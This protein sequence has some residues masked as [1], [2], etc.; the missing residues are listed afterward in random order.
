M[1]EERDKPIT[2]TY[3]DKPTDSTKTMERFIDGLDLRGLH[4]L[5][6]TK[7]KEKMDVIHNAIR[8]IAEKISES[9]I[10]FVQSEQLQKSI[11]DLKEKFRKDAEKAPAMK[12]ALDNVK[13]KT[14]LIIN[15]ECGKLE[16]QAP[17]RPK[18]P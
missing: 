11:E 1:K 4:T 12:E 14:V 5:D 8:D 16:K 13:E 9:G 17:A 15:Q 18:G 2:Y 7:L 6:K 10:Q 3:T